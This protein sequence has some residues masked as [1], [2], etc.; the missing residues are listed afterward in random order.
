MTSYSELFLNI[1]QHILHYK[2]KKELL[3]ENFFIIIDMHIP[4]VSDHIC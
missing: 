4:A 2:N 3:N 1:M